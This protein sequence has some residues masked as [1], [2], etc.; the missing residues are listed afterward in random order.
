MIA[1]GLGK[2][3]ALELIN[4]SPFFLLLRAHPHLRVARH[5]LSI[6]PPPHFTL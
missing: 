3:S 1:R 5:F 4:D 6:H 2:V